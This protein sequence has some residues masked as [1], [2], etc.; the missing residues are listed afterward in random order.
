MGTK[1]IYD[2][3]VEKYDGYA[4][5]IE[6]KKVN[7]ELF[8][9]NGKMSKYLTNAIQQ[10]IEYIDEAIIEGDSKRISN[11]FKINFLKPKGILI[12]GREKDKLSKQKLE[13]LSYYFHNI[14]ILTYDEIL[15]K[16]KNIIKNLERKNDTTREK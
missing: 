6:I 13:H 8:N 3:Y 4:D 2:F 7:E 15:E 5:I 14:E 16:S 12:I 9:K 10:L 11:K 1:K